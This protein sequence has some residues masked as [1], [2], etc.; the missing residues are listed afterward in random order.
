METTKNGLSVIEALDAI[1]AC[2]D[3]ENDLNRIPPVAH[4]INR[5]L[6]GTSV[7]VRPPSSAGL[8]FAKKL[9]DE[10]LGSQTFSSIVSLA[11]QAGSLELAPALL[12]ADE[13]SGVLVFDGL[14]ENWKFGTVKAFRDPDLSGKAASALRA[15]H[16]TAALS[17]T[18]TPF[19][20]IRRLL[21]E[22]DAL[23]TV[24]GAGIYPEYYHTMLDWT[25][26]IE[27]AIEAAGVDL[28]PCKGEN[29][30]SDF[31]IG[32]GGDLRLVDFDHA[33]N[34]DPYADLGVLANEFCRTDEDVSR[35]IEAYAGVA[36]SAEVARI[37][38]Y[39]VVSAFHLGLWGLVS[40]L[41]APDTEIEFYKYGQNQFLR[42]RS[43]ISRW[44]LGRFLRDI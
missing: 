43:A 17:V 34:G 12:T 25:A 30:L 10:V 33:A 37:K 1:Q 2:G 3:T 8:Y 16:G 26:R 38:L 22:L 4:P 5:G 40:Q 19:D 7:L 9:S 32:P 20:R 13:A 42:C 35:L 23:A 44:D 6:G 24:S 41:R 27:T 14:P 15:L 21:E 39:M 36:S 29:N 18:M 11:R 31:M 28:R